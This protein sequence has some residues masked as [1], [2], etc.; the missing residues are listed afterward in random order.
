MTADLDDLLAAEPLPCIDGDKADR[1]SVLLV[2]GDP[3]CPGGAILAARAALRA[4]SGRVQIVTHPSIA[5]AVGIAVPEASTIG[6][7]GHQAP[8]AELTRRC[9][10]AATVLIGPGL[11][12]RAPDT[13]RNL[14]PLVPPGTPLVLDARSLDAAPAAQGHR[15][16]V[17]PNLDEAH[18]LA[19][20]VGVTE[21]DQ[22][23]LAA[24]LATRLGAVVAV[25][26][27]NTL[28]TDGQRTWHTRGH[29]ALGTAGSGDVLAG[30]VAGLAA[31]NID[32]LVA[33]GWAIAIHSQAG[34]HLGGPEPKV[35]YLASDLPLAIPVAVDLTIARVGDQEI[36]SQ[37][38]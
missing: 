9:R 14:A 18:A 32:P 19:D 24:G 13:A 22:A 29:S 3:G 26:G 35:G 11:G 6:W 31:R 4:G 33:A 1:G 12:D 20:E 8:D 28:L 2:A 5:I 25:R 21:G 27:S 17:L 34:T 16:I 36:Q 37:T 15:L 38:R 23:H 10:E 30:L 7:D